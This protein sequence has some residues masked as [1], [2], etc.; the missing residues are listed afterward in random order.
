MHEERFRLDVRKNSFSEGVV[1]RWHRLPREG[2][3]LPLKNCV[4]VALRDMVSR[5][6][7]DGLGLH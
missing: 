2:W 3:K 5:H 1:R 7:G 6:G 4:H